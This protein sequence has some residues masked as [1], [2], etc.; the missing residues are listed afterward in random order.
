M[1]QVIITVEFPAEGRSEEWDAIR[2]SLEAHGWRSWSIIASFW[3]KEWDCRIP[4]AEIQK[5]VRED[6][7]LAAIAAKLSL[8]KATVLSYDADAQLIAVGSGASAAEE[9]AGTEMKGPCS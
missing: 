4:R 9:N 7:S 8:L 3:C 1:Q 6:L 5:A 2:R